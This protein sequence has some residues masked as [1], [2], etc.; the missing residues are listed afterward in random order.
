M[1]KTVLRRSHG[2]ALWITALGICMLIFGMVMVPRSS[3]CGLGFVV[4]MS[5]TLVGIGLYAL[6]DRRPQVSV[7]ESGL[8]VRSIG[9]YEIPWSDVAAAKMTWLPRSGDFIDITLV[10][11]R[12]HRLFAEGL[13]VS[14]TELLK[15][16]NQYIEVYGDGKAD[17]S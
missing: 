15:I 16:I 2:T 17:F 4:M 8:R 7:T 14:S 6:F 11:G 1:S 13:E 5:I 12:T 3:I 9:K 10:D